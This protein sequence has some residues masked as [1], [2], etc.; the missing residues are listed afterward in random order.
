MP[1]YV[2]VTFRELEDLR[3]LNLDAFHAHMEPNP[4]QGEPTKSG[5]GK[6]GPYRARKLAKG[7]K[8]AAQYPTGADILVWLTIKRFYNPLHGYAWPGIKRLEKETGLKRSTIKRSLI[9]LES[10]QL[11]RVINKWGLGNQYHRW[12][13]ECA[14]CLDKECTRSKVLK[15]GGS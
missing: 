12:E 13:C 1:K 8:R 7:E 11:L 5:N 4:H 2:P 9:S 14:Q 6:Q 3:D 15:F 10:F